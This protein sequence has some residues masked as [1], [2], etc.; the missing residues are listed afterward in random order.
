MSI[1]ARHLDQND[2][3]VD[4]RGMPYVKHDI[5]LVAY[6]LMG[7]HFHLLV[8][9][10]NDPHA[11]SAFMRSV[12]TAYTMYFNL[13]YDESGHLF[14]GIYKASLISNEPYLTHISRY[15][16]MNPKNYRNYQWSS[17]PIY[18]GERQS[19]WVNPS[20]IKDAKPSKDYAKFLDDY[21]ENKAILEE[22]KDSLKL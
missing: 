17:L 11:L 10:P 19:S 22:I 12:A 9:Q 6:R 2:T 7:N 1:L 16:H 13:R 3:S 14:Q 8:F 21:A 20:H 5:E 15:I 18:L 4:A